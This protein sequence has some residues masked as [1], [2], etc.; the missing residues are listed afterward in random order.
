MGP[1]RKSSTAASSTSASA[2]PAPTGDSPTS[3]Q[4]ASTLESPAVRQLLPPPLSRQPS[5]D[6]SAGEGDALF[7]LPVTR[8][9]PIPPV[10]GQTGPPVR[11]ASSSNRVAQLVLAPFEQSRIMTRNRRSSER[12]PAAPV[13][14]TSTLPARKNRSVSSASESGGLSDGDPPGYGPVEPVAALSRTVSQS[15][16][17]DKV[18][19]T[20]EELEDIVFSNPK[21]FSS[22]AFA[23]AA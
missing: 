18:K 23:I 15:G 2:S 1:Q 12:P 6:Q 4:R 3:V 13:A 8:P 11:A 14:S 5:Q 17:K 10:L 19:R 16:A 9:P 22:M 7:E 21:Q 20:Y